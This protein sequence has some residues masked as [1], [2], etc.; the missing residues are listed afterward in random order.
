MSNPAIFIDV[1]KIDWVDVIFQ[2]SI[3]PKKSS[4]EEKRIY[5]WKLGAIIHS[6]IR[7]FQEFLDPEHICERDLWGPS[8]PEV[9][10]KWNAMD[11]IKSTLR[12]GNLQ[13]K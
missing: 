6:I 11:L 5:F 2:L 3:H 8:G 9:D 12:M 4:K 7:L 10:R 13:K 1:E